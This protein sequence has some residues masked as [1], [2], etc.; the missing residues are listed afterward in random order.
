LTVVVIIAGEEALD[1]APERVS[2]HPL[3]GEVKRFF[4]GDDDDNSQPST[5]TTATTTTTT[6]TTNLVVVVVVVVAVVGVL[7]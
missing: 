6:T 4:P 2:T 1:L 7:G 5:P 3:R